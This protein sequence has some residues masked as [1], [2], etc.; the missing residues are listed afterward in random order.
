MGREQQVLTILGDGEYH[1]G[2]VLAKQLGI[3]RAAVWKI[4]RA[5]QE[6]SMEI[7]SVR[8]RGYRLAVPVEFLDQDRIAAELG[9]DVLSLVREIEIHQSIDSTN[10]YLLSRAKCGL[11][12]GSVCL[13]ELQ[14]AGR[15]RRGRTWVSPYAANLYLSLLWRF[16]M[17]CSLLSGLSLASGVAVARAL[18]GL[19]VTEIGLKWPNDLLW[20]QRK[21]GGILLEF[22]GESSG[23]CYVVIGVGLNVA[24]PGGAETTIDQPWVDLRH[25]LGPGHLSR[26]RLAARIISE[27]V[28]KLIRFEQQG[29]DDIIEEWERFDLVLGQRVNLILPT[30][31]VTGIARGTDE[32]GALLL[33]TDAGME[34]FM[35][36]EIS[37]R[38]GS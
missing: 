23:P 36:G 14:S 27:L 12:S 29:L 19:G 24:M 8:G 5:L 10:T 1:S 18:R 11:G 17:G 21:L 38:L 9:D 35:A 4:I 6:R 37:L 16:P 32:S 2:E 33:Q 34:R 7:Y 30:G 20:R 31:T 22:G 26:N 3:S 15:G 25:I 13:A 28:K